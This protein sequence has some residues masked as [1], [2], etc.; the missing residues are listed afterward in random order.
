MS[1]KASGLFSAAI[2]ESI[3]TPRMLTVSVAGVRDVLT[4][5]QPH[6][7]ST[8]HWNKRSRLRQTPSSTPPFVPVAPSSHR[9]LAFAN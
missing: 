5:M 2:M 3:P 6:T 8:S 9:W 7:M 4:T 1:P